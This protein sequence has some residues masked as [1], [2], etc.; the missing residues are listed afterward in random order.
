MH[1][2]KISVS[3]S[4]ES[5]VLFC[6]FVQAAVVVGSNFGFQFNAQS[7]LLYNGKVE[8]AALPGNT[9]KIKAFFCL[10]Y[11]CVVLSIWVKLN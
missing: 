5:I 3:V 1:Y 10:P 4:C 9:V 7:L 8:I 11:I 2:K 6:F